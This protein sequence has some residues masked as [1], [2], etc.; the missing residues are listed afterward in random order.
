MAHII[1]V[2]VLKC[3]LSHIVLLQ[4]KSIC[5]RG[6][7]RP[8]KK[9]IPYLSVQSPQVLNSLSASQPQTQ[10]K[11]HPAQRICRHAVEIEFPSPCVQR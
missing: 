4:S 8:M 6:L 5:E 11:D 2:I 1:R 7:A 3:F 9:E 10:P